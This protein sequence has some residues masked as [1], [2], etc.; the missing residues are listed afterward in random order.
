MKFTELTVLLPCH[1]LEDFPTYYEGSQADEL[2]AAWCAPWHPA[3]LAGGAMP[4]WQ[5][6]NMPPEALADRLIVLP[7][8]CRDRV[9]AD[10]LNERRP[11]ARG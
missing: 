9:P 7:A 6:V 5:R 10:F 11:R 2:L 4:N 3:L 8:F 1:S